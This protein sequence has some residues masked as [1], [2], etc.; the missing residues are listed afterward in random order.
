MGQGHDADLP[1]PRSSPRSSGSDEQRPDLFIQATRVVE[2]FS[3]SNGITCKTCPS[4]RSRMPAAETTTTVSTSVCCADVGQQLAHREPRILFHPRLHINHRKSHARR[5]FRD[6]LRNPPERNQPATGRGRRILAESSHSRFHITQG[7][8]FQLE[9]LIHRTG[10]YFGN[11]CAAYLL[12]CDLDG[13][14]KPS[15]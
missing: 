12:V 6:E 15:D 4:H 9:V 5:D 2:A 10:C 14:C 11:I 1:S 8:R 3:C 7:S 13:N